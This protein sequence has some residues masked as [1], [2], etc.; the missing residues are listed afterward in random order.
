[1]ATERKPVSITARPVT[2]GFIVVVTYKVK[3]PLSFAQAQQMLCPAPTH[4]TRDVQEEHVCATPQ[5]LVVLIDRLFG[6]LPTE[7]G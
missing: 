1:M 7:Q 5:A 4:T 6:P 3:E 2:G